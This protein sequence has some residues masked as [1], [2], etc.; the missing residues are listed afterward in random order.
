MTEPQDQPIVRDKR[1]LDP[2]TGQVRDGEP[3]VDPADVTAGPGADAPGAGGNDAQGS[4]GAE[5]SGS[6]DELAQART[7]A[8]NLADELARAR[9]EAYNQDQRFNNYVRRSREEVA[10]ARAAGHGDVVEALIPM[11]DEVD[12]AREH[13]GLEGPMAAIAE[14]I[15][16]TLLGRFNA[17]R[18][19]EVGDE[20]DPNLHEALMHSTSSEVSSDQIAQVMQPGYRIGERIIRPA[21]VAVIGPE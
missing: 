5:A 2:E 6:D 15:E 19:G 12:L 16:S 9:A 8:G 11:L 10:S 3:A 1:R 17:E 21:R 4:A 13:G 7:E 20:F 18:F 14:K